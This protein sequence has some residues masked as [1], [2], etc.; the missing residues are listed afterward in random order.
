MEG[1]NPRYDLTDKWLSYSLVEVR[2][3]LFFIYTQNNVGPASLRDKSVRFYHTV[4]H[5]QEGILYQ[6][7][8]VSFEKTGIENDLDGG[9]PFWPDISTPDD[10]L[11]MRIT[12]KQFRDYINSEEFKN[13][14]ISKEQRDR[15]LSIANSISDQDQLLILVQY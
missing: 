2:G 14:S 4:F 10:E 13:R 6:C 15:Q 9:Y 1:L 3:F 8:D 5:K 12:G 7:T 11:V